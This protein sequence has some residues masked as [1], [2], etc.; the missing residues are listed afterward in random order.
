MLN[1]NY[2]QLK[3]LKYNIFY[4]RIFTTSSF[5]IESSLLN[6][7][8]SRYLKNFHNKY[9]IKQRYHLSISQVNQR[10]KRIGRIIFLLSYLYKYDNRREEAIKRSHE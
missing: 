3:K 8:N 9:N 6:L 1:M 7:K 5:V 4:F 10:N 2:N